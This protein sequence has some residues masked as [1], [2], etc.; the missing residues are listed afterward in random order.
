[1]S[2]LDRAKELAPDIIRD[3]RQLHLNPELGM[4][5]EETAEYVFNRLTEMGYQPER[6]GGCGVCAVV[7]RP[8]KT[9]LLR[10]DMDALPMNEE[11]GLPFASK[12]PGIAH[13]CGHD[14][15]TA[16][17]LGAAKIL[18]EREAELKGTVKLMFQPGEECL[19]GARAM[20]ED[21]VLE[22]PHVDA[23][24]AFHVNSGVPAG[25]LLLFHGP[26][27]ASNDSFTI[28]VK[29]KGCHGSRPDEGVDPIAIASHIHTAL[30]ELQARELK[31]GEIGVLTVGSIHGGTTFNVIPEEVT[32]QGTIRTFDNEVRERLRE[33]MQVICEGIAGAFRGSACV[34]F[35]P[36]YAIPM[37]CNDELA[38][39]LKS[40]LTE[41]FSEKQVRMVE[42]SFPGSEDFSFIAGAVPSSFIVL[43][44][45]IDD[46]EIYGQHHPKVQFNEKCLPV[47]A[48]SF[49][50]AAMRWLEKHSEEKL[51]EETNGDQRNGDQ[52]QEE[53]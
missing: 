6:T 29:G 52:T 43:G 33:R 22:N 36:G 21:G 26:T 44:A 4:D 25:A 5:L 1:M 50:Y 42:K 49:A 27:A 9:L 11:S 34:S 46:G 24:M 53:G 18:K 2:Y 23:A 14:L 17:L 41:I 12:K 20:I 51:G 38:D 10:A 40:C 3:R 31:A 48:A 7:G 35:E 30:Q 16:M 19:M 28:T 45:R 8:G 32:M 15:H 47:G 37:V 39:E 13:C